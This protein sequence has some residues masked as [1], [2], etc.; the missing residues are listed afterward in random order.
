[1]RTL[2]P[3][4]FMLLIALFASCD[5]RSE[6][7]KKNMEKY[8]STPI[9][10]ISPTPTAP[11]EPADIVEVDINLQ[12]DPISI[13]GH[14]QNKTADCTK[15]NRVMVNGNGSVI[16]IKGACRQIMINGDGNEITANAA[17]EFVVNGSENIIRYSRFTNGKR[18][19]VIENR[20]GNVIEKTSAE[21]V[22]SSQPRRKIVK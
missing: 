20:A 12:G 21:T 18:P 16:M 11:I 13:N 1:M 6:I 8:T 4:F 2:L 9:P 22:T 17:M 5:V 14:G 3:I 10:S 19:S 15:F 7:A